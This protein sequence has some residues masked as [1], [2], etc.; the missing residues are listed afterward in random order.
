MRSIEDVIEGLEV[1]EVVGDTKVQ[2]G[3]PE[4]DSRKVIKGGA[5]VAVKGTQTDGHKFIE[6]AVQSGARAIICQELPESP[7]GN[8]TWVKVKDSAEA[9]AVCPH[10]YFDKPSLD[11]ELVGVTG[12][13]GKTTTVTLMYDLFMKMG[14]TT[15]LI[16]TVECKVGEEVYPSTHTTPDPVSLNRLLAKM[17]EAGCS[18]AFMEVSS[19]AIHQKRI[20]GLRFVGGVFTNITHDHL[21]YH[22]T[23][24]HYLETKKSFFDGLGAQAFALVNTDDPR[25]DVMVQNTKAKV[26]KY[27][28]HKLAEF[29][30]RILGNEIEGL[31]LR[32]DDVELISRL[33][34]DFNAYNLLAV[35]GTAILLGLEKQE[36]ITA[37]SDLTPA[38]GRF[39]VVREPNSGKCAIVDYAHTPDALKKVLGTLRQVKRTG[40]RLFVVVGCGGDRDRSKRPVMAKIATTMADMAILTS[41]NPR[42]EDP[43]QILREMEEGVAQERRQNTLTITDR[44]QAIRTAITMAENQDIILI[45][46]KGHEKYQ[47]INGIKHPFDDKDI[48]RK[49]LLKEI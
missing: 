20:A 17:V 27:S 23:F 40:S 10:N 39:D 1:I 38:E 4:I 16:S 5:F 7:D 41:D 36:T 26:S 12:T 3:V 15:G 24:K 19:H 48:V 49:A 11:L 33:V 31:H 30:A 2:I 35:Y 29:K 47:E 42:T 21:D 45:A 37:L 9:A 32:L 8:V 14:Y 22:G 13:N 25:G 43:E 44:R 46:G 34:G 6:N 28:L 18:H